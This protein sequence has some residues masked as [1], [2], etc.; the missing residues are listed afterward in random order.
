MA[1]RGDRQ[2]QRLRNGEGS[3]GF[4]RRGKPAS[5]LP[6]TS[7]AEASSAS[8]ATNTPRSP[9]QILSTPLASGSGRPF[10][11][12]RFPMPALDI[13]PRMA[14]KA[15]PGAGQSARPATHHARHGAKED[16]ALSS[17]V[18]VVDSDGEVLAW[19]PQ[20]M[21][22]E[23]AR[24]HAALIA[25]APRLLDLV[26]F[27]ADHM[28]PGASPRAVAAFAEYCREV[29]ERVDSVIGEPDKNADPR[30]VTEPGNGH[31][32]LRQLYRHQEKLQQVWG[33][34]PSPLSSEDLM[35]INPFRDRMQTPPEQGGKTPEDG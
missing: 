1:E 9:R 4:D 22:E 23:T 35:D 15:S 25:E 21:G 10:H 19:V 32:V 7:P 13:S 17:M 11:S 26:R 3:A 14:R 24:A 28:A 27:G 5:V 30:S 33:S 16:T 18:K 34:G 8:A 2:D 12:D 20:D 31:A 6:R 29:I